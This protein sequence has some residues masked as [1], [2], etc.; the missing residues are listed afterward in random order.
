MVENHDV[1]PGRVLHSYHY[2]RLTPYV[3]IRGLR[4]TY[5]H[6]VV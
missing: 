6:R 2:L 3:A 4:F 5:S 1:R